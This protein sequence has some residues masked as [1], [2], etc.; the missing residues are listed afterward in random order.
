MYILKEKGKFHLLSSKGMG[1]DEIKKIKIL[2]KNSLGHIKHT[3]RTKIRT[4]G[5]A[6]HD[7]MKF[8]KFSEKKT[9]CV[10]LPLLNKK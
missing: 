2:D 5:P 7:G 4:N 8:E 3:L 10:T 9:Y 6:D 1:K